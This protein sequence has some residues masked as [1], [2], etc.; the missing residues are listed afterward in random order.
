MNLKAQTQGQGGEGQGPEGIGDFP[1]GGGG[2]GGKGNLGNNSPNFPWRW[3]VDSGEEEGETGTEKGGKQQGDQ[4]GKKGKGTGKEKLLQRVLE[5]GS[6][7]GKDEGEKTEGDKRSLGKITEGNL[8]DEIKDK[9]EDFVL[10]DEKVNE[11][12]QNQIHE[13]FLR[14]HLNVLKISSKH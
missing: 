10:P 2:T 9:T 11:E 13:E 12:V 6:G 3:R 7:E 8:P 5:K 14:R 1:T 4:K